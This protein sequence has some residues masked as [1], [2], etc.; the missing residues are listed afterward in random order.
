VVSDETDPRLVDLAPEERAFVGVLQILDAEPALGVFAGPRA[1]TLAGALD[2]LRELPHGSRANVVAAMLQDVANP[3]AW[4]A[5][6]HP[7]WAALVG[8]GEP[9]ELVQVVLAT[10]PGPFGRAAQEVPAVT[11]VLADLQRAL[12]T[13][14]AALAVA[15][16]GPAGAALAARADLVDHLTREGARTLGRSLV[17]A[18]PAVRARA[19]AG[20]G[21]PWADEIA[22]VG[23]GAEPETRA[24]ARDLVARAAAAP[25]EGASAVDRLAM[26]GVLATAPLLAAEGPGSL[27]RV[28]G[29]LP[30]P[31]GRLL[32]SWSA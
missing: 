28:A 19:M 23:E 27:A 16:D 20:A 12:L 32:L 29:R 10:L 21:P 7:S 6:L 11:P 25:A 5:D 4:V 30:L 2:A 17:G 14:L 31:L 3:V 24:R 22:A 1:K 13:P 8:E 9:P 18:P 15:A 26:V